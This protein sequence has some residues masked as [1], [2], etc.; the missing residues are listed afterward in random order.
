[1]KFIHMRYHNEHD[2]SI[3]MN[4]D[5]P[6]EAHGGITAA[7]EV[8]DNHIEYSI[9]KCHRKD[10]FCK[11]VGRDIAIGRF[12]AGKKTIIPLDE[13]TPIQSLIRNDIYREYKDMQM[14][15]IAYSLY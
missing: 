13:K 6:V 10:N 2:L 5:L 9:A 11:K 8:K 3:P 15:D 1:M 12:L 14:F 4:E 7:Y